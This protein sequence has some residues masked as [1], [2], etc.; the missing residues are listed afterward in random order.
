LT[1]VLACQA[2]AAQ[3]FEPRETWPLVYENFQ[4]G[5][6]RTVTGVLISD[7][8]FNVSVMDGALLYV[9]KDNKI[10]NSDM[11]KVYTALIG[12]DLY[13]NVGGKMYK[14]LSELNLGCVL[15]Q[16]LFDK[17]K[18]SKV[19]IGYGVSSSTGS[20]MNLTLLLDGRMDL[21][22]KSL[23]AGEK[24]KYF[25]NAI[26]VKTT[27]Y[28][29]V[30]HRLIPAT[31]SNIMSCEGVDKKQ[32]KDFFKTEKIKWKETDS[33]EKIVVFLYGQFNKE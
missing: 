27:R 6:A 8:Q 21:I 28:I 13:L 2:V 17:D 24:D 19:D 4:K 33:L 1:F 3:E 29:Y 16:V 14:V 23:E 5:A 15:S 26:P 32:A 22:N 31:K 7:A 20:S 11:S 25:S 9:N 30:D 10:M 18:A 12:D